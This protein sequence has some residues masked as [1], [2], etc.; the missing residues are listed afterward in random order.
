MTS[1]NTD[2]GMSH[3]GKLCVFQP[4]VGLLKHL[5]RIPT[6]SLTY[7]KDIL[8]VPKCL[9]F[10]IQSSGGGRK[11]EMPPSPSRSGWVIWGYTIRQHVSSDL[12]SSVCV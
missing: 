4:A 10:P 11:S 9:G 1:G 6:N 5:W 7:E 3:I 12:W 2:I 8:S